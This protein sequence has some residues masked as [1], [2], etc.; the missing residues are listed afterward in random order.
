MQTISIPSHVMV[1]VRRPNGVVETLNYTAAVPSIAELNDVTL[2]T[3]NAAMAKANRGEI[4]GYENFRKTVAA[5]QP[6]AGDIAEAE[7][8][9][10]N[11]AIYRAS[12][13]GHA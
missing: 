2:K 10:R 6:S 11:A 9:R 7:Y 4:I 1:T 8:L 5:P 12:A 13:N 3:I